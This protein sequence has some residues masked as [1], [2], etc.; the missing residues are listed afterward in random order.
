MANDS[1]GDERPA[2]DKS[3][4]ARALRR[5]SRPP[6]MSS[7]G[8]KHWTVFEDFNDREQR[9]M[10]SAARGLSSKEIATAE[11]DTDNAVDQVIKRVRAKCGGATRR[12]LAR[13]YIAWE[14]YKKQQL[15]LGASD[16][17]EPIV[18]D[19]FLVDQSLALGNATNTPSERPSVHRGDTE[20]ETDPEPL[21]PDGR[22]PTYVSLSLPI[23]IGG[24]G[25]NEL[26]KPSSTLVLITIATVSVFFAAA[27]LILLFTGDH[28]QIGH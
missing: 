28:L 21:N 22:S 18:S 3:T 6:S 8:R 15:E 5:Q 13:D 7:P 4:S 1:A 17:G 23:G 25:R 2:N 14:I 24:S 16:T 12:K 9:I 27:I 11:G 19:P 20:S 10:H 26:D